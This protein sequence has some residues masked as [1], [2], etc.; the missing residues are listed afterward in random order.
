MDT[1]TFIAA[2]QEQAR[3]EAIWMSADLAYRINR[4]T[5]LGGAVEWR[6]TALDPWRTVVRAEPFGRKVVFRLADGFKLCSP[7]CGGTMNDP[8]SLLWSAPDAP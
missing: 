5:A 4:H 1:E 7:H 3:V 6:R 8:Y 2:S